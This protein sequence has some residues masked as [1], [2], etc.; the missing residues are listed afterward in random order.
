MASRGQ[1]LTIT[2]VAWDT[3][4][5]QGKTGDVANHTLRWIKDGTAAAPSNSPGEVDPTNAPGV[6]K[7]TLTAGECTCHVGVLAGVSSTSGVSI[8]PLAVTFES[9]SEDE[10]NAVADAVLSRNVS[11]V[12]D[13]AGDHSL[14]FVVLAMSESNTLDNTGKLTVYK[15]D[16]STEFVQKTITTDAD[17]EAVTGI[18]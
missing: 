4:G 10:Q 14:C 1:S 11:S 18:D 3:A 13:S 12:E 7:I 16:G 17:A 9:I 8:I 6:Y 2:Y 5:N 15:T